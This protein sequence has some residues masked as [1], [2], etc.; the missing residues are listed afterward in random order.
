MNK[1]FVITGPAGVGKSTISL[2]IAESLD[3]SVLVEGD[4]I[5]H[6]VQGGY[7]APW[8]PNNHLPLFWDNCL[9]IISNCLNNGYDVVFNYILNKNDIKKIKDKFPKAEIKFVV[10]LVDEKTITERDKLR[11][12]DCQMGERALILLKSMHNSNFDKSNILDTSH[13]TIEETFKEIIS[14]DKFLI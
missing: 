8:L 6:L 11:P 14:N 2:K 12:L 5:Y 10:L 4:D 13:S 3:K 1:I 7:I 9:D